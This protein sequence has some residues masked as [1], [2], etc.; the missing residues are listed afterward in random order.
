MIYYLNIKLYSE[1]H[2]Y[3]ILQL[4]G[5]SITESAKKRILRR[6]FS[7]R[8]IAHEGGRSHFSLC[9]FIPQF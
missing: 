1:Q 5:I 3:R 2:F 6:L 7:T 4:R 8:N 9:I